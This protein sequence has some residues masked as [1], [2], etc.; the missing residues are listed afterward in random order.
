MIILM[1]SYETK[2]WSTQNCSRKTIIFKWG[3]GKGLFFSFE[4]KTNRLNIEDKKSNKTWFVI[5]HIHIN[6]LFTINQF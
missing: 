3:C 5:K 6:Y 1:V 2:V 4:K